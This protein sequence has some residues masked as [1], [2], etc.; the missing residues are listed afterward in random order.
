MNHQER[1]SNYFLELAD[2]PKGNILWP[3]FFVSFATLYVEVLLIRWIGTEVRVFAYFQNLALIACFLGFGVGC[4]RAK[5]KKSFLFD[6]LALGTLLITVS[7]PFA[8][9]KSQLEGMS[10]QLSFSQD[11]QLWS[12]INASAYDAHAAI[13][14]SIVSLLVISIFLLLLTLTMIPL[15]QWVGTYLSAAHEPMKAYSVNLLGSLCGIWFFAAVSFLGLAPVYWFAIAGLLLLLLRPALRSSKPVWA[16]AFL[17]TVGLCLLGFGG[18][19]QVYWSP[20]QKLAVEPMGND[21][22]IQVNNTGYMTIANLTQE[23]LAA[24]P[25]LAKAYPNSSY[26]LPFRLV[27]SRDRVLIVGSGAGNDVDAALRN[28]AARV[29]AV[30]IDPVIYSLGKRLHPDHPYDSP[31]VHI[32]INDARAFFRQSPDKFDVIVFGL[33]D[34][35]TTFSGYS[36]MRVD[37]YVYTQES[38]EEAKRH[39]KPTGVLIVKFEVRAP[40]TWMGQR[41]YAMFS[42]I[43]GRPPVTYYVPAMDSLLSAT[44]F[45]ASNDSGAWTR[46]AS[47][48][49]VRMMKNN[50]APF[51]LDLQKAPGPTT[52]DWPY[53]YHLGHNIP[54]IYLTV[55]F[56]VLALAIFVARGGFDPR[57]RSTWNF[58]FLGAG[59]LLMETQIISRLALYFGATWLVNC[60]ALSM[61]L[62]VLVVSNLCVQRRW[63]VGDLRGWYLALL[64]SLLAIYFMPWEVLPFGTIGIGVSLASA[65]CVPLFSA[66]VIFAETFRCCHDKSVCFGSNIL[67]AVAGGLAQS[68]SFLFGMKSL[69]LVAG[70]FYLL[71]AFFGGLREP[72]SARA[73]ELAGRNRIPVEA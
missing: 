67:G 12:S 22:N 19:G 63:A 48:E 34:S 5:A 46:A 57:Q 38:F 6:G 50:P 10:A 44:E 59:F 4:Y 17:L 3:L 42:G 70:I 1:R 35:H 66:G 33:L 21:Y 58:F 14:L 72:V 28:G 60:I 41:F 61:V 55:S 45:V 7:L 51:S 30:E 40:S 73:K 64:V 49:F 18:R 62:S 9:W 68:T 8:K 54:G 31:R 69:L 16:G 56:V 27:G 29:D 37:N 11:A 53:V 65:Y 25:A 2:C 36:N 24:H 23:N 47:P 15:G 13:S 71:A 20:Y 43:F 32:H 26:D 39:L 52:D